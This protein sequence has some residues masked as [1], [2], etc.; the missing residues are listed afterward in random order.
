MTPIPPRRIGVVAD[1][2]VGE[3][4][5]RLPPGVARALEDVE[6]ILHAGDITDRSAL[7]ELREIAPV[8]AVQGDHDRRAGIL[9][10]R[11][12]IVEIA[13][14]RIG[15]THG[16]RSRLV[17]APAGIAS[18]VAGRVV[19]LGLHAALR[20]RFGAID[21]LVHGH[22]H[23]PYLFRRAGVLHFSPGAVYLPEYDRY[24]IPEGLRGHALMRFRRGLGGAAGRPAVGVLE[25]SAGT[26]RAQ[27][28]PIAGSIRAPADR[29]GAGAL[30][31][32]ENCSDAG[33][34]RAEGSAILPRTR[35]A[36]SSG[37]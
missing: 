19:T 6:L 29:P 35:P 22:L 2:H 10:P 25:I 16:R 32:A 21:C 14:V 36:N 11:D 9:L 18:L 37:E 13:G 4:L 7:D 8:I 30:V 31:A 3:V 26:I 23:L 34:R 28:H 17:E 27:V 15:L 20:R 33:V 1:T 5:P 12:R 24:A